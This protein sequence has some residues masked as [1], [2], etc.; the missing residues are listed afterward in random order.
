VGDVDRGEA[1]LVVQAADLEA[2]FLAQIGVEVG[3]RLIQQQHRG[4][5]H[6]G[7]RQG[8]ALLLATGQLRRIAVCQMAEMHDIQDAHVRVLTSAEGSFCS[9]RPKATFSA[10]VMFGQIA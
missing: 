2:H 6:D 3:Q 10:T 4:L 7:A 8:H 5:H 9:F 1:E